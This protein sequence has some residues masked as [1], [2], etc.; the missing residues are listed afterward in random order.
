NGGEMEDASDE[1]AFNA[2]RLLG[3]TEG[4]SVEPATAVAFA[5]LFKMVRRGIIK[6]D[7]IVVIN[8]SGHTFPVE[9]QILGDRYARQVDVSKEG[10]R[11]SVPEEGLLS[12]LEQME[13]AVRRIVVIEDNQDAG[14][15]IQRILQARG[16]YEVH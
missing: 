6:P 16:N 8:C 12:A 2:T 5:G 10:M 9:K 3:R 14:R 7:E 1:E 15:L 13:E 11:V 4:L